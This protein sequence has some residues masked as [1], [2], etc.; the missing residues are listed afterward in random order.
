MVDLLK[1]CGIFG[2]T[3]VAA[4]AFSQTARLSSILTVHTIEIGVCRFKLQDVLGGT[5]TGDPN[6]SPLYAAY[7][8]VLKRTTLPSAFS[9]RFDCEAKSYVNVCREFAGV[10]RTQNGWVPWNSLDQGPS[11]RGA[12]VE[13][14]ELN[15]A[16]GHGAVRLESDTTGDDHN[17]VRNLGFCLRSASGAT[18]FGNAAVDALS[19]KHKSVE[20][21]VM[22]LLHSIE[23]IDSTGDHSGAS[24]PTKHRA[25]GE[26]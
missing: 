14:R 20:P 8:V 11:L 19:G 24:G 22:Q 23:F 15:S 7:R 5:V 12:R 25:I 4:T 26:K 2:F 18:L 17:R 16:N 13:V 21:E 6:G 10:E 1:R 3:F 9:I